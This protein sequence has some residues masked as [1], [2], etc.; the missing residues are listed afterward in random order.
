MRRLYISTPLIL[1]LLPLTSHRLQALCTWLDGTQALCSYKILLN[2]SLDTRLTCF[3]L[4]PRQ[5][6]LPVKVKII[7]GVDE[8]WKYE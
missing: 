7:E 1:E 4:V 5:D 8:Q 2:Y 6:T 3:I